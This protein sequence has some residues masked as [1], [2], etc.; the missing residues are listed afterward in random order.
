[1]YNSRLFL[2]AS[3]LSVITL[4]S[5]SRKYYYQEAYLSTSDGNYRSGVDENIED[6][7]IEDVIIETRFSGDAFSYLVFE[8]DIDNRSGQDILISIND[9]VLSVE[10][11]R[12]GYAYDL[13]PLDK[14]MVIA[15]LKNEQQDVKSERKTQNVLNAVGVGASLL[16]IFASPNIDGV[17]TALYATDATVS[18]LETDRAYRLVEGDIE[19]QILY[20]DEWVLGNE[21]IKAGDKISFD[22]L[23]ERVLTDAEATMII[24]NDQI[25]YSCGY[26]LSVMEGEMR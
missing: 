7:P 13:L 21:L 19:D 11:N 4:C 1:M 14:S 18:I 20:I 23:F 10:E 3:L 6:N 16:S 22:L 2:L 17:G 15:D 25:Q 12:D 9:M 26:T 24:D 5:C 8:I